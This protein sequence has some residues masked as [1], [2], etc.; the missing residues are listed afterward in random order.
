MFALV[1]SVCMI[2]QP[3]RCKDVT[4]NFEGSVPSQSRCMMGGQMEMAKWAGE[5]P[6]WVI[7]KWRCEPAGE[8]AD[9]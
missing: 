1:V 5:H 8:H 7:R 4:M 9:L 2:D 3:A 6:N